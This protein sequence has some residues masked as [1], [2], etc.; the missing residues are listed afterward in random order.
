MVTAV[1]GSAVTVAETNP[2]TKASS[3]VVVTLSGSTT[4]TTTASASSSA[5]AVGQCARAIG[6][7]NSTGAVTARSI[8]LSAPTS[9]GCTGGFG[10]FRGG[11]AASAGA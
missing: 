8:T 7:A 11:A 1:S 9:S 3:S 5:L 2:R 10:G 4:F 6:S